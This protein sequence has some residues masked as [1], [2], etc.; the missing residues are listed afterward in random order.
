M[1]DVAGS[2]DDVAR[3]YMKS[4]LVSCFIAGLGARVHVAGSS[5]K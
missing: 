2:T 1:V 4:K 3:I 5:I